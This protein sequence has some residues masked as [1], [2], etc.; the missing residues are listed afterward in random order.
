[1]A[2]WGTAVELP[3]LQSTGRVMTFMHF[4]FYR[5]GP[6]II[7]CVRLLVSL[8][9]SCCGTQLIYFWL[10]RKMHKTQLNLFMVLAWDIK[11][12]LLVNPIV[13]SGCYVP[14]NTLNFHFQNLISPYRVWSLI[15][16]Y[17][18]YLDLQY[19]GLD[20][21]NYCAKAFLVTYSAESNYLWQ[22]LPKYYIYFRSKGLNPY[23]LQEKKI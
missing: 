8:I 16:M 17:I 11:F 10:V 7:P 23:S 9:W 6:Q 4:H 20:Y 21:L 13:I 1:M 12:E 18:S 22:K 14:S 15:P 3:S 2:E 19:E 5:W